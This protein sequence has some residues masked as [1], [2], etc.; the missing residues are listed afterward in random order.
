[1]P[2]SN[3]DS[4]RRTAD[5]PHSLADPP[6]QE[7]A[8]LD[9]RALSDPGPDLAA[10]LL[11]GNLLLPRS[12]LIGR[13][14][15]LAAVQQ[16]LLQEQV[17]LLTL[18]GPGG[19]GKTRLAMQVAAN[20]LDHFVDGVYFV[21][22]APIREPD[23]VCAVIAQTWRLSEAT[24]RPLQESLHDYLREKQLLLVLDN[25]EQVL[26]AAP[27]V[28]ALLTTCVRLKVLVTSRT[29]LHLYGEH[30][31]PVPPLALPQPN[32]LAALEKEVA[33]HAAQYPALELFRQ[34]AIAIQP[35]FALTAGNA[36]AV[37]KICIALDGLPLAIEL[38]AA[39]IKLFSPPVLLARLQQRLPLL[40]GGPHDLP[41]RQR[42]LRDEI[43]WSYDL[44][45]ADEQRLFRR[46]AVFIG[47]FT[48]EAA[49]AVG[50]GDGDLG[51]DVL[52]GV[53]TLVDH[54]LLKQGQQSYDVARFVLLETIREYGLEQLAASGEAER[55][56]RH[57][58]DFFLALA[59]AT[60]PM[61]REEQA[62]GLARLNGEHANLRAALAWSLAD[63]NATEL[64]LRLTSALQDFWLLTGYW[65]EGCQWFDAAL[66][67]T[68]AA[69]RTV[70]RA[71]ALIG[72]S[73]LTVMLG[74]HATAYVQLEEGMAIAREQGTQWLLA[75]GFERLGWVALAQHDDALA[76]ARFR[77]ALAIGRE[78]GDKY[79]MASNLCHLAGVA[80]NEHDYT[81]AQSLYEE[82]LALFQELRAEWDVADVLS[83][84]GQVARLQGDYGRA[85][86][87]YRD[88]LARWRGLGTLQWKGAVECLAGLA[89]I[90]A[91]QQQLAEAAHL[92]GAADALKQA[93]G[94]NSPTTAG[95]ERT[96]LRTQLGEAP[97]AAAWAAGYALSTEQAVD[98]VLALPETLVSTSSPVR[99][100]PV[101]PAA[102]PYPAGLSAREVEVLR[103]LVQGLTYAQ[104]ADKLVISR[105]TVN[106]HMTSIY[107]KLGVTSR[108]LATRFALEHQLV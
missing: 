72:A 97:F 4:R 37:A 84:E 101:S 45:T 86:A 29:M 59:E 32:Q 39:R 103:L 56:R 79:K 95:A 49:E 36:A 92:F 44:L 78:I 34:R 60:A 77:E 8:D 3:L 51:I 50:N 26:A 62:K 89:H 71:D 88:S 57:Y 104:I 81:G 65:R 41:A 35:G 18:T 83:Y 64:A 40:T 105:R 22:L 24:G 53:T 10:T 80:C 91:I 63:A 42:T 20:L 98:Y 21:S 9:R 19:I 106:A 82:S 7:I 12:P 43:A 90:Y 74:D 13:E 108:A 107:G 70:A 14:H 67:R 2:T 46:L 96:A 66:A 6:R 100:G 31:F 99:S 17:G 11:R 76:A 61:L 69:D 23:Q 68:T 47:G 102:P 27:L 54:N 5:I 30:E 33:A 25:F 52:T 16:L 38:A 58:A 15:E 48:L 75:V 93:L 55:I 73:A 1:M 87:L 94:S 85:M 28:G